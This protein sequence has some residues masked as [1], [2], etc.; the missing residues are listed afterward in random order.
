MYVGACHLRQYPEFRRSMVL[1]SMHIV[2]DV[3][4]GMVFAM[5]AGIYF[6]DD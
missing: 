2:S 5:S 4:L 1:I 6:T 3:Y